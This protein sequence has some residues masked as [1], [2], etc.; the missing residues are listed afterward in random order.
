MDDVTHHTRFGGLEHNVMLVFVSSPLALCSGIFQLC[1]S[2]W[3][4][5]G[6]FSLYIRFSSS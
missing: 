4:R 3:D 5:Y 6:T 1:D 2:H